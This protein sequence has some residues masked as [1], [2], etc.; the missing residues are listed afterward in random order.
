MAKTKY[1]LERYETSLDKESFVKVA[2]TYS[3][4]Q[5]R[6]FSPRKD[7]C[8]EFD[9]VNNLQTG[10]SWITSHNSN[11]HDADHLKDFLATG[12]FEK[13][14]PS[15]ST[16]RWLVINEPDAWGETFLFESKTEKT[17]E[18]WKALLQSC[19]TR[20][21]EIEKLS[22]SE[23]N[24]L[25]DDLEKRSYQWGKKTFLQRFLLKNNVTQIP[26]IET[27]MDIVL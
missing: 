1:L 18:A 8:Y 16:S 11:L 13:T 2:E 19:K 17:P 5:R 15:R 4:T 14:H 22:L 24:A 9:V 27:K 12:K 25:C 3:N 20:Y 21:E 6:E 7:G 23:R 10:K 26:C